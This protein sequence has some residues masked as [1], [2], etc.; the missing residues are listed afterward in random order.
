MESQPFETG[1]EFLL[2]D[3]IGKMIEGKPIEDTIKALILCLC[4]GLQVSGMKPE[5][6]NEEM[7]HCFYMCGESIKITANLN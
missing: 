1:P 5:D 3:E 7:K 6:I 4:F 2:A